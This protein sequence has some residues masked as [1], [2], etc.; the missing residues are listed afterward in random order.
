VPL[1]AYRAKTRRWLAENRHRAP[2]GKPGLHITDIEPFRAWQ[3]LLAQSG[4]VGVTW[5]V[6]YGGQGLG[7]IE[8]AVVNSEL[9]RAGLP[10]ALDIIGVGNLAPTVIVHGTVQ[11]KGIP[12]ARLTAVLAVP[13]PPSEDTMAGGCHWLASAPL[14]RRLA[15]GCFTLTS[16]HVKRLNPVRRDS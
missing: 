16:Q 12:G 9:E 4:L 14:D 3:K 10:G 6:E 5:P 11:R 13:V 15:R 7:M 8:Q 2:G 1:A